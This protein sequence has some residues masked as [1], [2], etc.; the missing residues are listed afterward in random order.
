MLCDLRSVRIQLVLHHELVAKYC[1]AGPDE[2]GNPEEKNTRTTYTKFHLKRN[3]L[4]DTT[5]ICIRTLLHV[6][7][8]LCSVPRL[9]DL[10]VGVG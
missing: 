6:V 4:T 8:W 7:P 9:D 3:R 10:G 5:H 2:V 1:C